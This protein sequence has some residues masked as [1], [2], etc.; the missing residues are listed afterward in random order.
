M[1]GWVKLTLPE[2]SIDEIK[3]Y[4]NIIENPLKGVTKLKA[5]FLEMKKVCYMLNGVIYS[6]SQLINQFQK[7]Y[8]QGQEIEVTVNQITKEGKI[9]QVRI[10]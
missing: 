9:N 2:F 1:F 10:D 8:K 4:N 7:V 3:F 6:D 5:Y